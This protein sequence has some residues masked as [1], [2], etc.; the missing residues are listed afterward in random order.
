MYRF[1][2]TFGDFLDYWR[3]AAGKTAEQKAELWETSY[4]Q[5]HPELLEKQT[6]DYEEAGYDW[7]EMAR[8]KVFP[9]L[10][11]YLLL[12]QQA[13]VNLPDICAS[14]YARAVQVLGLDFCIVFVIYVGIGCG[15]G[16]ATQY[17]GCP[18]CLLGLEK[19]AELGWSS[20]QRLDE[21]VCHEI[22]HLAHMNWRQESDEFE[23]NERDPLFVLYSEGFAKRCGCLITGR[24][25]WSQAPSEDWLLWC[26]EHKGWLARQYLARADRG[27]RVNDFFGD[28]LTVRGHRC[29]GY[30]LGRAFT[31]WLEQRYDMKAIATLS[32]ERVRAEAREYLCRA[33]GGF[34]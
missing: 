26:M 20:R 7:R 2:D 17:K 24:E 31:L 16:W 18:A 30:Y 6:R 11:T 10:G 21:L 22:G 27:K 9:K 4:M 19:I 3:E 28:W 34:D 8:R 25:G 14:A 1:I 32:L 13:R 29:A 5:R 15:A 12:M 23:R 33:A